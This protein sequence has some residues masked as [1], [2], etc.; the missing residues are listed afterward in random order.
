M[1]RTSQCS[2]QEEFEQG[3]TGAQGGTRVPTCT[4]KRSGR[5]VPTDTMDMLVSNERSKTPLEHKN[6]ARLVTTIMKR[7]CFEKA[8]LTPCQ[9]IA[10]F[11]K[12]SVSTF[13]S[14]ARFST[15]RGGSSILSVTTIPSDVSLPPSPPL[16][17]WARFG[18]SPPLW[19]PEIKACARLP[20]APLQ[21]FQLQSDNSLIVD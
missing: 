7:A 8:N 1:P 12:N 16:E 20:L 4:L 14:G 10:R 11:S 13:A 17:P 2:R 15:G 19:S 21:L 18:N 5:I 9:N 6:V 3:G